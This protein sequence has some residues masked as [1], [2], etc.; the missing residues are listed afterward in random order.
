[1]RIVVFLIICFNI[2]SSFY[3]QG[4]DTSLQIRL[5]DSSL[6]AIQKLIKLE[7]NS[8]AL[9][10]IKS[11]EIQILKFCGNPSKQYALLSYYYGQYYENE[12]D[13]ENAEKYFANAIETYKNTGDSLS[14][15][16]AASY[17]ALGGLNLDIG[18]VDIAEQLYL[19]TLDIR[20]KQLGKN[21]PDYSRVLNNL[22]GVAQF[23]GEYSKA[24]YLFQQAL[25]ITKNSIGTTNTDYANTMHNLGNI[26]FET[27]EYSQAL[28]YYTEAFKIREK[29]LGR[30]NPSCAASLNCLGNV[31]SSMG[32]LDKALEYYQE[33]LNIYKNTAGEDHLTT[34][35]CLINIAGIYS[36]R[37]D[38]KLA[39]EYFIKTQNIYLKT[40]GKQHP[41][42]AMNLDNMANMYV[43]MGNKIKAEMLYKES[44]KIREEVFGINHPEYANSLNNIGSYFCSLDNFKECEAY[45]TKAKTVWGNLFGKEHPDYLLSLNNLSRLYWLTNQHEKLEESITES[46]ALEQKLI[47]RASKHLPEN[48]LAIY[49]KTFAANLDRLYS[50]QYTNGT[51]A[52]VCFDNTLFYKGYLLKA[53]ANFNKLALQDTKHLDKFNQLK[54]YHTKIANLLTLPANERSEQD[55][56]TLESNTNELEKELASE[57][58]GL[59][60]TRK[61]LIFKDVKNKLKPGQVAIEFIS[62]TLVH[63]L[64]TDSIIYA[65]LL[66]KPDLEEPVFISLFEEK[67]LDSLMNSKSDRKADYVNAMYT[68]ANRGATAI[69]AKRRNL[70]ELIFKPI[71]KELAGITTIYYSPSGLLHR[72]NLD[73][74]PVSETET[75]ADRYKLVELNSTRQLVIPTDVKNT[76]NDAVVFGGIKFDMDTSILSDQPLLAYRTESE[77]STNQSKPLFSGVSWDYLPGTEREVNAIEKIMTSGGIKTTLKKGYEGTEEAFK[78]IGAN[79]SPSPRILHVATHGYFFPDP[80]EKNSKSTFGNDE[81]VFK[82]S[83]HPMLRS[84]LIVAGGNNTWKGDKTLE[85]REDGVLT[86]YEISQMNLSNTELVVLSACETGLGT[87]Q[88]NEGVYGLQRAFKIAGAKYLIMSLWQV[89]DKQTSLLMTTF[90]RKWLENKMSIP[91]AFHAAQKELRDIGLDPYQWA[92]FVLVE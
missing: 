91:D 56:R 90:Y 57:I 63:P 65:A 41:D 34:A 67:S 33:A 43:S 80:K 45:L 3:A 68:L 26:S 5:I 25:E 39:E 12:F 58:K 24:K 7:N 17:N 20:E 61:N 84:G 64:P 47:L 82:L 51:L 83:D 59:G 6:N 75:L 42:Y 60:D 31:Y 46:T 74:I 14:L 71:E 27:A 15:N 32:L 28:G 2:N 37:K 8:E 86:A 21:H 38:Y 77:V 72:I 62:F 49:L 70:A 92:G 35:G 48:E 53:V 88:G 76:T 9:T 66:L 19:L 73:A 54:L 16:L 18:K 13:Y 44:L 79:N 89:P 22:A 29:L 52:T 87:I 10:Q 81:P 78:S 85:G 36:E 11:S 1:M 23:R 4:I 69:E 55:I 40:I 30:E 50:F